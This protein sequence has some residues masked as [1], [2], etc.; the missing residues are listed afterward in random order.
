[1]RVN[2]NIPDELVHRLDDYAKSNY[3]TRSSIMCQACDYFLATK[4]MQ[5]LLSEMND[6]MK[7]ISENQVIDDSAK[8][9]L[10]DFGRIVNLMT[11]K[12]F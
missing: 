9:Q 6:F 12:F 3:S 4:Q 8:Q 11:G 2:L 5:A 7:R 10:D 1:M